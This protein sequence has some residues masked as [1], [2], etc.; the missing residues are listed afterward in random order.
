MNVRFPTAENPEGTSATNPLMGFDKND[1]MRIAELG[2]LALVAILMM[3]FIVRPLL[4]GAFSSGGGGMALPALAAGRRHSAGH[5]V[6]G[7]PADA[8][9][10][11][12]GGQMALPGPA[13]DQKID[14][15]RI[16]GQVNASSIKRVA[17]FVE[18]H[19]EESVSILRGWLHETT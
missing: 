9:R 2:V 16:E 5:H 4:K 7:R 6:G 18:K 1:I 17:E 10:R 13:I 15:A 3:L 11:R 12:V 14:M 19:P 8:D